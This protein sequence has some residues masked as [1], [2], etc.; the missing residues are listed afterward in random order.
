MFGLSI[1]SVFALDITPAT[2]VRGYDNAVDFLGRTVPF[3][4]PPAA[5]LWGMIGQTLAIVVLATVLGF[6]LSVPMALLAA[7]NTT[8]HPVVRHLARLGIVVLRAVPDFIVAVFLVRVFGLGTLPGILA[9]GIGSVGMMGKLYADAIEE[10]DP[11]PVE[12]LRAA[13]AGRLQQ[14]LGGVLP[15]IRPQLVATALH[16]FDINL[17][18]S[19]LLGFVGVSGIGMYISAALD[20]MNYPRGMGLTVVLLVLCLLGELASG[21]L[22]RQML[23]AKGASTTNRSALS[24]WFHSLLPQL[25]ERGWLR[26]GTAEGDAEVASSSTDSSVDGSAT[27]STRTSHGAILRTARGT[28]RLTPPWDRQRKRSTTWQI[29]L[30]ALI[31]VSLLASGITLDQLSGGLAKG[32]ETLGM[33]LPP[34]TADIGD[35]LFATMI[36]TIQMG[37][38]GT[39]LGIIVAIPLGLLS[40]NNIVRNRTVTGIT[41]AAVVAIRAIPD[42]IIGI[43]FVVITGLGSTAGALA[44]TIGSIGFFSKVIADS[45]EEVDIRVQDAVRTSGAGGTQIFFGA[46]LHQVMPALAGHTMHQLDRNIRGATGLGIIGAGGIGFYLNNA[47]R[48][49]E[50]GVVTTSVILIVLVVMLSEGLAIWTR[51][52]VK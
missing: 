25:T 28:A 14:I 18:G 44:L 12:A 39:L 32:L 37:L 11:G 48:V 52:E 29:L 34:D 9:L 22:R 23:G 3:T 36:E 1:W 49:L 13:G 16:A 5:E 46:T 19:I 24:R 20:T 17:R 33:Y 45:M 35:K 26:G 51:R 47:Q 10:V 7:S 31:V 27:G 50:Y 6:G 40:A 15:Q 2:F 8:P 30:G 38:A 43:A 42:I 41:R 4:F 21:L